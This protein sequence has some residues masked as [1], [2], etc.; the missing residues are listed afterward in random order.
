MVHFL[1]E[2]DTFITRIDGC[3]QEMNTMNGVKI[4]ILCGIGGKSWLS[5]AA[6]QS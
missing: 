2:R 5:R 4:V 3:L 1:V 6:N